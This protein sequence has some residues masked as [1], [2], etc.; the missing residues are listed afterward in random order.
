MK[1]TCSAGGPPE[2]LVSEP[3]RLIPW[4]EALNAED[5]IGAA[6]D[7]LSATACLCAAVQD[8]QSAASLGA[9]HQG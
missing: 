7:I 2:R 6:T 9:D 5:R 4:L 8:W 1:P 3:I